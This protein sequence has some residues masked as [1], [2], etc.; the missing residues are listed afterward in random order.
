MEKRNNP[1]LILTLPKAL[2]RVVEKAAEHRNCSQAEIVK[3]ALYEH[4]ANF[5][6][7]DNQEST[8]G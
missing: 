8:H 6:V 5:L 2:K 1:R 4:L 7:E 3:A